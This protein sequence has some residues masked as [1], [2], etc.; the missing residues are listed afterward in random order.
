MKRILPILFL[1]AAV[2][3]CAS[4][5]KWK[6]RRSRESEYVQAFVDGYLSAYPDKPYAKDLHA[7]HAGLPYRR[8]SY[9]QGWDDGH[10]IGRKDECQRN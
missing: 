10:R 2:A 5:P 4:R 9:R 3:G 6:P 1:A 8:T 7:Y